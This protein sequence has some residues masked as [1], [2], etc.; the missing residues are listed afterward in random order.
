MH[1]LEKI[2]V[3]PCYTAEFNRQW[4]RVATGQY[5]SLDFHSPSFLTFP[6]GGKKSADVVDVCHGAVGDALRDLSGR[7]IPFP[8]RN[9]ASSSAQPP[10][11]AQLSDT[12][13]DT[14]RSWMLL[15]CGDLDDMN[16]R[17]FLGLH[18]FE[19]QDTSMEDTSTGAVVAEL[20]ELSGRND[21]VDETF[22]QWKTTA[23]AQDD[24]DADGSHFEVPALNICQDNDLCGFLDIKLSWMEQ[25]EWDV[26]ARI[27][28]ENSHFM[29]E[30]V[31]SLQFLQPPQDDKSSWRDCWVDY[32]VAHQDWRG[33]A[34]WIESM[35]LNDSQKSDQQGKSLIDLKHVEDR[36][37]LF[38]STYVAEVFLTQ[39]A[40]RGIFMRQNTSSFTA[41][42]KR[43]ALSE[44]LFERRAQGCHDDQF[45][46]SSEGMSLD[47]LLPQKR[48]SPFHSFFIQF[49]VQNQLPNLLLVYLQY[50]K[51]ATTAEDFE[52]LQL[53][54]PSLVKADSAI[55]I[56]SVHSYEV[57]SPDSVHED[58]GEL[59]KAWATLL[60]AG[61]L[62]NSL[63]FAASLQHAAMIYPGAPSTNDG[64]GIPF[65]PLA[66]LADVSS[67]SGDDYA[68]DFLATLMVS[69]VEHAL[70]AT[71]TEAAGTPWYV[72]RA[73]LYG[74]CRDHSMLLNAFFPQDNDGVPNQQISNLGT[75]TANSETGDGG[76]SDSGKAVVGHDSLV[77]TISDSNFKRW[78]SNGGRT[79]SGT[80]WCQPDSDVYVSSHSWS[81]V[82]NGLDDDLFSDF[83]CSRKFAWCADIRSFNGDVGLFDVL[84]D[85]A[86]LDVQKVFE[87]LPCFLKGRGV[88]LNVSDWFGSFL[89]DDSDEFKDQISAGYFLA[90]GRAM[91]A[92]HAVLSKH[93]HSLPINL[94]PEEAKQLYQAAKQ[95]AFFNLLN[96]SVV[97]STVCLLELCNLKTEV[98]RVDVQ[99]ARRIG[100]HMRA[101]GEN[102]DSVVELFLSFPSEY[103]QSDT[104]MS[105]P[106]LLTALRMLE[107]C[108]WSLDPHPSGS[109]G[110]S[111][112]SGHLTYDSP[113]HLVALFCRVHSLPRSL[114]L[115][116]ELARNNDWVMFLHECDLQQCPP[117]T[118][119]DI[120]N[121][122]FT[123]APLQAHLRILAKTMAASGSSSISEQTVQKLQDIKSDIVDG[124]G[125][126]AALEV[127]SHCRSSWSSSSTTPCGRLLLEKALETCNGR[128][129]LVASC[130]GDVSSFQCMSAWLGVHSSQ[131]Y[132]SVD[133][134]NANHRGAGRDAGK[135]QQHGLPSKHSP[136]QWTT[137]DLTSHISDLCRKSQAFSLVLRAFTFFDPGNCYVSFLLFHQ[138]F[139]Q[140][141]FSDAEAHLC[142][143]V[144]RR[145]Q[146]LATSTKHD[147][148]HFTQQDCP[149]TLGIEHSKILADEAV[150]SLLDEYPDRNGR[151]LQ[152]LDKSRFS[153]L[154]SQRYRAFRLIEENG[155][156][157][158][159]FRMPDQELLSMLISKKMFAEA[160]EWAAASGASADIVVF[161]EVTGM[162]VEFRQ[163]VFWEMLDERL[164][165]WHKC[166]HVFKKEEYPSGQAAH[167]FLDLIAK[168]E[169]ELVAREQV[170]LLS[171]ALELYNLDNNCSGWTNA[172]HT[173]DNA[174][175]RRLGVA[176]STDVMDDD[177]SEREWIKMRILLVL[178]GVNADLVHRLSP[179]FDRSISFDITFE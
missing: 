139:V 89:D 5:P 50:Y 20:R 79:V 9:A 170:M 33:I 173:D 84:S 31:E 92:F 21:I 113:W 120:V 13:I 48:M 66:N 129:C 11:V 6:H 145:D 105:S 100:A 99:V 44:R 135:K 142:D 47:N 143:F 3:N 141:R 43:L 93:G 78:C 106:H 111:S 27:I 151:L 171:I 134:T 123:D 172:S 18:E 94:D 137:S 53:S 178:V 165:L 177:S 30:W 63:L 152:S 69:P 131:R 90:Q 40:R 132:Q 157:N 1:L 86:E 164:Q 126:G 71:E 59:S 148:N 74:V 2:Y 83:R 124:A 169:S 166:Y 155:L 65:L 4:T 158:V 118:V 136:I 37:L 73:T 102:T 179:S 116:H 91:M 88:P 38:C 156:K 12:P 128:L 133:D 115:L 140:C 64:K 82:G 8:L 168:L 62:G 29:P 54:N 154:Y 153:L 110:S 174:V 26:K 150:H 138:K 14:H 147:Q 163:G 75:S 146:E 15:Q 130:F 122:Y 7:R 55:G 34:L 167:F 42:L 24:Q 87:P 57:P 127:L 159:D 35:K 97:S 22:A 46:Y 28:M 36:A 161:E 103:E 80:I 67:S 49:C 60:L 125:P 144:N 160:R 77:K 61:R 58:V 70:Q 101:R 52:A 85:V 98:L 72:P 176:A 108:T 96:D 51:L 149:T 17:P 41:L 114:T 162:L 107:E 117:D 10:F 76:G 25:W 175:R 81:G 45:H 95:A 121:G 19:S 119:W 56:H 68:I 109:A 104:A 32:F 112:V 16:P 39:L 23:A